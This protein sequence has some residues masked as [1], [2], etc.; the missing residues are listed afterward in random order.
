VDVMRADTVD[1]DLDRLI[2]RRASQ[3]RTPDPDD[4]EPGYV[5]S[6]RLYNA[7]RRR[8]L[9]AERYCF[10]ADQAERLRRTMT[11]LVERHERQTRRILEGGT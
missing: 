8:E 9:D 5:E 11:D 7:R 1:A 2:S 6:V 4:L 10:H 3:D